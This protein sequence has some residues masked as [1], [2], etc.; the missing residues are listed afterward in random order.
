MTRTFLCLDWPGIPSAGYLHMD[1]LNSYI[2]F[3]CEEPLGWLGINYT[4]NQSASDNK[5]LFS[6]KN[7]I[8]FIEWL[9]CYASLAIGCT[10]GW[11]FIIEILII[12]CLRKFNHLVKP[13]LS[14]P[15][16]SVRTA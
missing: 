5:Q 16:Q 15:A 11:I 2:S 1:T 12:F 7:I 9:D 6:L 10:A 3:Y 8:I 14:V 4:T 13:V